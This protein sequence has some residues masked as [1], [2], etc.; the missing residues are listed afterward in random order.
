MSQTFP[1]SLYIHIPFCKR[2][3]FYCDFAIT[4]G[5]ENLKQ[6][7]V[8]V[9]CQEIALTVAEIPPVE[10]LQ[11]IFF[12]G[13][14]PS[15]LSVKQ[16]EQI[17]EA[18][19][20]NFE[21]ASNADISLEA[22]AGTVSLESL[23]GYRSLGVNRISLGAQ[24]FQQELLDV[25]GRGHSVAD[26]YEAVDV[27]KNAGFENF[28][29][30]LISGLPHQSMADWQDSLQKA[31]ALEPKHLSIYDLT[32]E[33]GTAFGKRYQAGDNPLPTESH[34]V[35]MYISAHELLPSAGY[36]HYEI[37]NYAQSGYQSKHN[38]TYWHN[39]PFYGMGMGATSYIDR[40]RI[41]R[42]Q[43]MRQ[44]LDA[45]ALWQSAGI[46]FTAPIIEPKEELMDSLM[47]GLR[48]AEGLSL[49]ALQ[50]FYG[51]ELCDRALRIL[52]R[53]R[54]KDWVRFVEQAEDVRIILI[55]PNGWLFSDIVIADLYE[56][57]QD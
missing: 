3:C 56:N 5:G 37:S 9:L 17:L 33:E 10:A 1:K 43:K 18:I 13:G 51:K 53:Y 35:E 28:S 11:T 22:N 20:K 12:G 48:L 57:L 4:T 19:A 45:V 31:I 30:D 40:Q 32:I 46:G 42:P 52:D 7:Y 39:Q 47:Q 29:L 27:I 16:L 8:D 25:C 38:L 54:E 24:A 50:E 15:L 55:S 34:T 36:E 23:Q 41:D 26:I 21:I 2:R 44:Y 49:N 14:T 6:Q